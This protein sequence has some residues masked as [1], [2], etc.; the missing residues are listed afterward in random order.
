[1]R[2]VAERGWPFCARARRERQTEAD[3]RR[4]SHRPGSAERARG[5]PGIRVD[6][7]EGPSLVD[8]TRDAGRTVRECPL[9]VLKSLTCPPAYGEER[10]WRAEHV[11][12]ATAPAA[13]S[14]AFGRRTPGGLTVD[15]LRQ[16][17]TG[18]G[19]HRRRRW[20]RRCSHIHAMTSG[21]LWGRRTTGFAR[22]RTGRRHG[23][24]LAR[25]AFA[26]TVTAIVCGA[27]S[28]DVAWSAR[29]W[30]PLGSAITGVAEIG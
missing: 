21:R 27:E 2:V 23:S 5:A 24:R 16:G 12:L 28:T 15:A 30:A 13:I 14:A 1:V 8:A 11:E 10:T 7:G 3:D 17:R 29:V 22:S 6:S 18:R 26:N 4:G 25:Q 9:L 19:A 20:P